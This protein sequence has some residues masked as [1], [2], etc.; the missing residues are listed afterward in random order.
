MLTFD[1]NDKFTDWHRLFAKDGVERLAKD[2]MGAEGKVMGLLLPEVG[3]GTPHRGAVTSTEDDGRPLHL[4][5]HGRRGHLH[6]GRA[7]F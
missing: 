3:A 6:V 2:V 7:L 4:R 1:S 5:Q